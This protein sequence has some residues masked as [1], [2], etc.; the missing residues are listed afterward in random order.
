MIDKK[1]KLKKRISVEID[2]NEPHTKEEK[3]EALEVMKSFKVMKGG[4]AE[5]W[6]NTR[7]KK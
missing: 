3:D 7:R 6:G 2:P 5:K 1:I 4:N